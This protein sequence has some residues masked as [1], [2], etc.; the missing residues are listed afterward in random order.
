MD[1]EIL[2]EIWPSVWRRWL[3]V[4]MIAALGLVLIWTGINAAGLGAVL[5]V[6]AGGGVLVL[7]DWLRRS[8]QFSV[9]LT[10]EEVRES[11]GRVLCRIEDIAA[12][13]RSAFAFKPSN[14]MLIRLKD[15]TTRAWAPG[16][17][18][19]HGRVVGIGGVTPAP[20]AKVMGDILTLYLKD[21]KERADQA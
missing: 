20:Q 7:S 4:A 5:L 12:V 1:T 17:W 2:A 11:S 19:R 14:G 21:L 18:W 16:L 10:R 8:T 3:A 9:Q 13:D 15:K 6:V